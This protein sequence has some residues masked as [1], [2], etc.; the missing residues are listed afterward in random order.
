[1][2]RIY[3]DNAATT[4]LDPAVLE[5]MLPYMTEKFGN[6]S[7]IYSYGRE[8]RLGIE[9][10]RKSVAKTLNAHPGE[11]FF[12]SGGTEAS[13]TAINAAIKDL[14]CKHIISSPIEHHATLHTVEHLHH[15]GVALSFVKLL[16]D[17]HIDLENL[18]E[19][20]AGSKERS[21]VTLMHANNEIGNLLDIQAVG[22]LCKE[23]DAIFHSD[24]VQTVGHYP[25]DLRN[26]PVH[27]I[28]GA[29]HK[30]HGPKGV[31]ILYINENVKIK[32]FIQGGSQE[33]NMR[34]GTENL[35]GI[36]GFAKA[37]ELATAHYE[38]HSK[39]INDVR[40]YMAEQLQQQIPG[41]TFNGDL[42][43]RSL[44]TVLNASF[45]KTEKSEMIL[46]NLDINGICASG[47]SACTSGADAGS[48]VIRSI[49]SNPNQIAV[50]FSFS[51][52]NTKA[53]VD[54][55]IAKLKELI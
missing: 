52:N 23:F 28:T 36:I 44:Y 17:G 46:F 11:I 54:T 13:N 19:L 51:K 1:M 27:F 42:Y 40:M 4:S 35:Y 14:G 41:V 55:V 34:A 30:F 7:S 50:R 38:E 22:A 25:F 43:G 48:H 49:S 3:F 5:A 16:P 20:L 29:G 9:N 6:P 21:L 45:P 33:R 8:S 18:R 10:A 26:T 2:E 32:P 53:E 39:H 31:G 24:T 47:G 37:L 15:D 12:T